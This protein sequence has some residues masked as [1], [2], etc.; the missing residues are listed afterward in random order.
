MLVLGSP[1]RISQGS[2]GEAE[3][4]VTLPALDAAGT[5]ANDRQWLAAPLLIWFWSADL[6]VW[7]AVVHSGPKQRTSPRDNWLVRSTT[8][9]VSQAK[10]SLIQQASGGRIRGVQ[11][12][13]PRNL[14]RCFTENMNHTSVECAISFHL[15]NVT[16]ADWMTFNSW[17]K[18]VTQ[19]P[20][21]G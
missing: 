14:L 17:I 9:P 5:R 6:C 11:K 19:I 2:F 13:N 20:A 21:M 18:Q 10:G 4:S 7:Q 15:H 8:P 3:L 12:W 1:S 16:G